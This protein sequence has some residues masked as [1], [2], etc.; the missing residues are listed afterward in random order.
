MENKKDILTEKNNLANSA[1]YMRI[2][3]FQLNNIV[4]LS[5]GS[6][7]PLILKGMLKGIKDTDEWAEDFKKEKNKQIKE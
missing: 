1:E 7:D 2:R 6:I 4:N 5:N 3:E